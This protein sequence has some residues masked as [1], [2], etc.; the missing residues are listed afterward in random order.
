MNQ[1]L[2]H[3]LVVDDEPA[4]LRFLHTSLS[5]QQYKVSEAADGNAALDMLGHGKFDALVLC[6]GIALL[7]SKR[8]TAPLD[9]TVTAMEGSPWGTR[10]R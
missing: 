8:I 5:A 7:A 1:P 10:N 9:R 4:I 3:I 6:G 2:F